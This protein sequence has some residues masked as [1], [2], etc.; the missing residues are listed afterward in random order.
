VKSCNYDTVV[1]ASLIY[2]QKNQ[3]SIIEELE[4]LP[5]FRFG[6]S[7]HLIVDHLFKRIMSSTPWSPQRE[8]YVFYPTPVKKIF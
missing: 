4:M 1:D 8:E 7:L 2:I 3:K 6:M 5:Y